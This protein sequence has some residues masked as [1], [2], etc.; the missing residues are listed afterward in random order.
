P[1]VT[2]PGMSCQTQEYPNGMV[3]S[4]TPSSRSAMRSAYSSARKLSVPIGRW[5]PCCSVAPMG[6]SATG[7]AESRAA[8][9]SRVILA[10]W[11]PSMSSPSISERPEPT[12]RV[13]V[14]EA[15]DGFLGDAL[16]DQPRDEGGLDESEAR[17]TAVALQVALATH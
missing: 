7:W 2:V 13:L 12:G 4:T 9:S 16:G 14:E 1:T 6:S 17:S 11:L 5:C 8:I 10:S 15:V 3:G